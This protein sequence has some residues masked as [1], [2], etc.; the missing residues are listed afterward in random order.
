MSPYLQAALDY[1]RRGFPVFPLVPGAKVPAIKG[2]QNEAT[3]DPEKIDGMWAQW[4]KA[5]IGVPTERLLVV[6]IDPRNQGFDT[7][8]MLNALHEFVPTFSVTTR[9]GGLHLYYRLP[10]GLTLKGGTNKLGRG[11]D[12]KSHGGYV[13]GSGSDADGEYFIRKDL[14]VAPAPQWLLDACQ[15]ARPRSE[16]AGVRLVPEDDTGVDLAGAWLAKHA[17]DAH[18][19]EIDD[20]AYKVAARLYDYGVSPAT[21]EAL[22]T[23]WSETHAFPPM[24]ADRIAVIARS[25]GRN[26]DNAIGVRHP[27]A[28][29]FEAVEIEPRKALVLSAKKPPALTARG[30][31]FFSSA[32][33]ASRALSHCAEPL[34]AG[35]LDCGTMSIVYGESNSGKSFVEMDQD[36]HVALGRDW[37]GRKVKQGVVIWV[38][39]EGGAGVYKR[40][41]VLHAKYGPAPFYVVPCPVNLLHPDG[42]SKALVAL[43]QEVESLAGAPVVKITLDTLSRVISGGDENSPIDM[44]RLVKHLDAI[45]AVTAAHLC[46]IH[47]TGKDTA[48][49]ARGH[50]L[51]RAATDT[52]I[53][54]KAKVM[55]VTK[56]RDMDGDVAMGFRLIPTRVGFDAAGREVTSCYVEMLR[57]GEAPKLDIPLTR[58]ER[59]LIEDLDNALTGSA[60]KSFDKEFV[61]QNC[62]RKNSTGEPQAPRNEGTIRGH[63][64]AL[65]E[66][67]WLEKPFENSYLRRVW[68]PVES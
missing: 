41:A 48:K 26:R 2:W 17:P 54:I 5:N 61:R 34:V 44:G 6:D 32:E 28:H 68:K 24:M 59:E 38:A 8:A 29:G 20:T 13:V 57:P 12:V 19:G 37:N 40:V 35:L 18:L 4:P 51:L 52:E 43:I 53:E 15:Q 1:A 63:L 36:Y 58:T 66:K 22:L 56:Q 64:V 11:V 27:D 10:E 9:S 3:T 21:A 65:V 46:V 67:G 50:S 30:L 33:A 62:L 39:A 31:F 14:P 55:T 42:D 60:D 49:G 45:R 25:A 23:E 7:F 16:S 47:H